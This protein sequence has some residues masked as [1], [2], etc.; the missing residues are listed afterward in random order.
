MKASSSHIHD[1]T[2]LDRPTY[3]TTPGLFSCRS[4]STPNK[5]DVYDEAFSNRN[6]E[7]TKL[8]MKEF[9]DRHQLHQAMT[10][11]AVHDFAD[12]YFDFIYVDATHSYKVGPVHQFADSYF[13]SPMPLLPHKDSKADIEA[14][15]P[16][17]RV[18]G[19]MAG[20][21]YFNGFVDAANQV[22]L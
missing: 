16:K 17:L 5:V 1:Y 2:Q 21:D 20:D 9:P 7:T 15:W 19:V 3:V 8:A 11:V 6:L 18:G 22:Q 4:T 10:S 13:I 14:Y 12:S